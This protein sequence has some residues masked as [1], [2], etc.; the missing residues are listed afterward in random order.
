[1]CVLLICSMGIMATQRTTLLHDAVRSGNREEVERLLNGGADINSREYENCRTPLELAIGRSH[2]DIARLLVERG[3]SLLGKNCFDESLV[4]VAQN[5]MRASDFLALLLPRL[6]AMLLDA[7]ENKK[8]SIVELVACG[9][10]V[11]DQNGDGDTP[12]HL[13]IKH[14]LNPGLVEE[15]ISHTN[16]NM[17][18]RWGST[19][20]GCA[21]SQVKSSEIAT[22]L[23]GY[24]ATKGI[25]ESDNRGPCER[26]S[27]SP[28]ALKRLKNRLSWHRKRRSTGSSELLLGE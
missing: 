7:I 9:A 24:G 25:Y 27:A 17:R 1:M 3:A 5:S 26:K 6:N 11:D 20:L 23:R 14:G 19:P 13:A 16:I 18:N 2:L 10:S 12:L 8:E 4:D 22:L 15:L 28:S 21:E